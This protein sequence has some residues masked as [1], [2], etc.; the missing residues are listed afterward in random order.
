MKKIFSLSLSLVAALMLA[1][2]SSQAGAASTTITNAGITLGKY[3]KGALVPVV[4]HNGSNVNTV[5]GITL[6]DSIS[7]KGNPTTG[8]NMYTVCWAFF[9]VNSIH[10]TD[11]CFPMTANGTY[12]FNWNKEAGAGLANVEGY[13]AFATT[14][15]TATTA[16]ITANAFMVDTTAHDAV[17]VPV[18]PLDNDDMVNI[19]ST[20]FMVI[21]AVN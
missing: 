7:E 3:D 9:D 4:I 21:S 12:A 13:I 11:G 18:L 10:R 15:T 2:W 20:G 16:Q 19:G 14:A 6:A 5:V 17:F 8:A 1:M